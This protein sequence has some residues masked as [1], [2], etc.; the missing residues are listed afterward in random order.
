MIGLKQIILSIVTLIFASAGLQNVNA[1]VFEDTGSLNKYGM[2]GE[3]DLPIAQDLPDG[4]FSVS[5]SLFGGTIR[6]NLSFQISKNLTGAFQ[7]C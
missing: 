3:I 4:Q 7:V 2:P 1:E 5:S 6:V